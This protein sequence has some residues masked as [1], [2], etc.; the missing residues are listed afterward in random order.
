M[1]GFD[2]PQFLGVWIWPLLSAIIGSLVT[3][4]VLYNFQRPKIVVTPAGDKYDSKSQAHY[5][6]LIVKNVAKGFLGGGTALNCRGKITLED[7]RSFITKW[8]GR[9]NPERVEVVGVGTELRIVRI[10]EPVYLEQ[11]KYEY[12]RPGDEKSL[13]VAVRFKG[14]SSC[15]IHEPENFLDQNYRPEKNRL[16]TGIHPFAV[17]LEYDGYRSREFRFEIVNKEGDS[18]GL[19]SLGF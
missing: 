11:A 1:S 17:V 8:A 3:V 10:V 9:A 19:L 7:G 4:V 5:V 13:D 15:Y 2:Y 18:P 14:E 6:H 16:L 12:L